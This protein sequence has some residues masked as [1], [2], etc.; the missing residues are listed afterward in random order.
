[1]SPPGEHLLDPIEAFVCAQSESWEVR[2]ASARCE[3]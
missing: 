3:V 2:G 1:M